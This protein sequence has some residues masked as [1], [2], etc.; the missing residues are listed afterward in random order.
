M[1]KGGIC[2]TEISRGTPT[3]AK[4]EAMQIAAMTRGSEVKEMDR[5]EVSYIALLDSV[6]TGG[7]DKS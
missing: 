4:E 2:D 6:P 1:Y 5:V 3:K 7:L